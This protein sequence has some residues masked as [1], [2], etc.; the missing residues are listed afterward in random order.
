MYLYEGKFKRVDIISKSKESMMVIKEQRQTT[1]HQRWV[2]SKKHLF[3]CVWID[4]EL[5]MH[6]IVWSRTK[7]VGTQLPG[8]DLSH[9]PRTNVTEPKKDFLIQWLHS[10]TSLRSLSLNSGLNAICWSVLFFIYSRMKTLPE[11]PRDGAFYW[12]WQAGTLTSS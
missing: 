7:D 10:V 3:V 1:S 4:E 8:L 6:V 11:A 9:Y 5:W 2:L 12:R